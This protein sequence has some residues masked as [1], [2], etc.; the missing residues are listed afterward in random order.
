MPLEISPNA[1]TVLVRK[2]AYERAGLVRA[3][4]DQ[5]LNLTSD[6]FRLE[7]DLIAIGPLYEDDA[8]ASLVER[9]EAAGLAF[10]DDYFELPGNWPAWTRVYVRG[11]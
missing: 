6:E 8:V 1:P 7:G 4:I 11:A 5:S 3:D 2:A 9:L 10:F